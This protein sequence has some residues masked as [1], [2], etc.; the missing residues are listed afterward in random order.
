MA[1]ALNNPGW[2]VTKQSNQIKENVWDMEKNLSL[3]EM[4]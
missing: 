3:I 2:D 1:L 4:I